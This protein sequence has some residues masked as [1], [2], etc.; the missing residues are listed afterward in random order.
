MP[1]F[2]SEE[3]IAALDEA[4]GA[5]DKLRAATQS[6]SLVLQQTVTDSPNG[7]VS[8]HVTVDD[9]TIRVLAGSSAQ[10]ADVTFFQSFETAKAISTSQLSAQSAFMLGK[11]R[12]GG[13]V[14]K[15]IEQRAAFDGLDD[16]FIEV[17][18]RTTY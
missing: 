16:L 3:W 8:W 5:D 6:V 1:V 18:S 14:A 7:D 15:L 9:G 2:L 10:P 13:T 11:L 12:I 17:R 4:A